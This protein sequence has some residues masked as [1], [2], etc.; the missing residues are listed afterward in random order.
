MKKKI[1]LIICSLLIVGIICGG[2]YLAPHST[3]GAVLS[4]PNASETAKGEYDLIC[5]TT[6]FATYSGQQESTWVDGPYYEMDY[7][8][9]ASGRLPIIKGFDYMN[10]DFD[11]VNRRAAEWYENGGIVTICWHCGSD[12]SGE[13]TDCKETDIAD[14]DKALTEGTEEYEKLIAGMDKGAM[15]LKELQEK[16]IPVLWRPFHEFDGDWFWWSRGGNESFKKLWRLMYDRYTNYHGLNNLIWVLGYS[17]KMEN[18][19]DWY[20]GDEYC[21]IIGADTYDIEIVHKLYRKMKTV[22]SAPKPLC[23]HE[24]GKNPT[25]KDLKI[26]PWNY[27]MTWHTEYLT[28]TNTPEE[29]KALYNSDIVLTYDE[30]FIVF[31]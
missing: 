22:T 21:D 23:L 20:P 27:F 15:A 1:I 24:C 16:G 26:S 25:E 4:N 2:I 8:Y 12:F 7:I 19:K 18:V 9:K 29:L 5:D 11:G 28:E 10:D 14:W 17:H 6:G 30:E 31:W 13:W 3:K